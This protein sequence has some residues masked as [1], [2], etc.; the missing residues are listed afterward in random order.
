MKTKVSLQGITKSFGKTPVLSGIE[1]NLAEGCFLSI[2][3]P[4]GSGK[5]TL[6]RIIA[7]FLG[8]DRGKVFI[9][10][11]DVTMEPP[12]N[13]GIGMVFQHYALFPNLTVYENVA[14][15]LRARKLPESETKRRVERMLALVHLEEKAQS[16]PREL[17][18]GQQQRVALAR[19]LAVEPGLLLLD[20]PLSALDAKV[21]LEL[22][23]EL[24]RIQEEMGITTIYVT[25]DQEEALS[26]SDLVAVLSR[27]TLAQLGK[28]EE[29]YS[30]PQT[31]FV[32]EF[33]GIS[34][35]LEVEV[36]SARE[37]KFRFQ[38]MVLQGKSI[39]E[40]VTRV[41]VMLRPEHLS[42]WRKGERVVSNH[43]WNIL[44]GKVLGQVFL[45][46][47][48]RLAIAVGN[49][50][51]LVDVQNKVENRFRS[52]EEVEIGFPPEVVHYLYREEV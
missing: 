4:S 51:F 10:G 2:V 41:S 6:L 37:G 24:K 19:A 30:Q 52:G 50:T 18:G 26:I 34:T 12:R 8:P 21:R 25:H 7:G 46:S 13:R 23:Y 9:D 15:G 45:G 42:V 22:R 44:E 28:P 39:I 32:A 27:G 3:G 17:S 47:L 35:I 1:L 16:Y 38:D 20:E 43:N 48:L 14:F 49:T 11:K 33:I 40:D 36:I 31:H 5:T 29:V